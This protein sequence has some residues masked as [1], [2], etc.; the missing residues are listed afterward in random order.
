MLLSPLQNCFIRAP[1]DND[2]GTSEAER[3]DPNA[4]SERWKA[5]GYNEMTSRLE[6]TESHHLTDAVLV[7]VLQGWYAHGRLAFLS[8]KSYRVDVKGAFTL[9]VEVE[10][11]PGLPTRSSRWRGWDS[12]RMKT[13][14]IASWRR[15]FSAGGCRLRRCI[16]PTSFPA[17]TACAAARPS[18][19]PAAGRLRATSASP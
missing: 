6:R 12:V 14:P 3:I 16:R 7:S 4:W 8:R 5:A 11:A 9:T 18:L 13:T 15:S 2:I 1:L 17:R 19:T 10:Q